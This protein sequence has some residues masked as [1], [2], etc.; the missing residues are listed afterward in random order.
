MTTRPRIECL[1]PLVDYDRRCLGPLTVVILISL[2]IVMMATGCATS[3]L[4]PP[5]T[6]SYRDSLLGLGKVVILTN[7]SSHHLYNVRVIGRNFEER[8]SASVRAAEHLAPGAIIEVG[9]MEFES[10]VPLSGETIEVYADDYLTPRIS[11]IP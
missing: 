1:L 3:A 8:S 9:W 4:P 10:W 11:T 5:V 7:N 2:G 6:I